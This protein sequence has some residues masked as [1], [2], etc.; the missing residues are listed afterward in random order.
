MSELAGAVFTVTRARLGL[1]VLQ[2]N[3]GNGETGISVVEFGPGRRTMNRIQA[4]SPVSDGSVLVAATAGLQ[5]A[6]LRLR[7]YGTASQVAG[8]VDDVQEAFNQFVYTFTATLSGGAVLADWVCQPADVSV[9]ESGVWQAGEL[10]G[11][12]QDVDLDVPRQPDFYRL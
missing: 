2:L 7:L 3:T 9:G 11:G 12:W 10:S 8:L 4:S 5:T 6:R 1:P